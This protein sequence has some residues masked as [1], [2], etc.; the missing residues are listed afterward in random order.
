MFTF[1]DFVYSDSKFTR[2]REQTCGREV[3]R[4]QNGSHQQLIQL[5]KN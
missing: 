1:T 3:A 4:E 2:S 5:N